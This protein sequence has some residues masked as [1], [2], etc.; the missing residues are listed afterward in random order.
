VSEQPAAIGIMFDVEEVPEVGP[1]LV[2]KQVSSLL[3]KIKSTLCC[4]SI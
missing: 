3:A 4:V 1:A 2:V